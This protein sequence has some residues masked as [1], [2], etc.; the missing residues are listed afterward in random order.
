[1]KVLKKIAKRIPLIAIPFRLYHALKYYIPKLILIF[2]WSIKSKELS[3]FTYPLTDNN[4]EY[5]LQNVSI[6]TD[7]SYEQIEFYYKEISNNIELRNYAIKKIKNSNYIHTKDA[8]FDFASRIAYYCIIRAMKPK[9][10]VENGVELGYTGLVL[11]AAL[12]KNKN[13]GFSGKY[14]GFDIDPNAG[15]L[16]NDITYTDIGHIIEGESL[17]ILSNFK[18]P[19]DFYFSDGDRSYTYE[20]EELILIQKKLSNNGIVASNKLSFSN[21]LSQLA[22]KMNKK[23]IYFKEEPLD[24]W[25][26]GSQIGIMFS[27]S[28]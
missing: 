20:R 19:I 4:I 28:K 13:E 15:L 25:Y 6:I 5:L 16:I 23:H 26:P 22:I 17:N 1:M 12:Q 21:S 14:Y 2:K 24:H 9:I 27:Y 3:T 10:V 7:L 8:R 18:D 11:C